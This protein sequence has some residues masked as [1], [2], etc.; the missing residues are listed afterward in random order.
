[1]PVVNGAPSLGDGAAPAARY[2]GAVGFA[3]SARSLPLAVL[4]G[5]GV[6][7]GLE[8]TSS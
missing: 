7:L 2:T 1:M 3:E 5:S 8:L 4:T 6:V